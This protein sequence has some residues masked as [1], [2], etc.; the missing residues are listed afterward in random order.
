MISVEMIYVSFDASFEGLICSC[1]KKTVT[2]EMI[3]SGNGRKSFLSRKCPVTSPFCN[4]KRYFAFFSFWLDKMVMNQKQQMKLPRILGLRI[5]SFYRIEFFTPF[6][7]QKRYFAFFSF[8]LDKMVMTKKQQMKPP[9][10]QGSRLRKSCW[11]E[12]F[13]PFCNQTLYFLFFSFWLYI[14]VVGV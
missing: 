9:K 3:I 5:K 7:N 2:T 10:I 13:T 11:I 14:F 6:C 1:K 4:Q 12:F 8:W